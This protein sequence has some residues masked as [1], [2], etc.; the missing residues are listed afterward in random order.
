MFRSN[1]EKAKK[2]VVPEFELPVL[3]A[4]GEKDMSPKLVSFNA[5]LCSIA[6]SYKH[7]TKKQKE[8][9]R[10]LKLAVRPVSVL[11]ELK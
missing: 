2:Y 9:A 3:S 1:G 5:Y 11:F 4:A 8:K 6:S 7:L 10:K